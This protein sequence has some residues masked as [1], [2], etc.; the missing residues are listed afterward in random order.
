MIAFIES[1]QAAA[2]ALEQTAEALGQTAEAIEQTALP[3]VGSTLAGLFTTLGVDPGVASAAAFGAVGLLAFD[4][5]MPGRRAVP[6][7]MLGFAIGT[8][9]AIPLTEYLGQPPGWKYICAVILG[10]CGYFLLGGLV[11]LSERFKREPI[12]TIKELKP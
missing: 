9:G 11:K 10:T 3:V 8:W 5:K 7:V 12:Q 6:A 2:E 4:L 1:A